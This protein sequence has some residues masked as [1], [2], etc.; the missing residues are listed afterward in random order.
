[1]LR[2]GFDANSPRNYLLLIVFAVG[3]ILC[4]HSPAQTQ[5]SGQAL[6]LAEIYPYSFGSTIVGAD[7]LH[8]DNSTMKDGGLPSTGIPFVV[9]N[10][11]IVVKDSK[12]LDGVFLGQAIR[13]PVRSSQ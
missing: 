7:Y 5:D 6:T 13:G 4:L 1:M 9:V 10:G 2:H 3:A 8:P 11:T 12:V